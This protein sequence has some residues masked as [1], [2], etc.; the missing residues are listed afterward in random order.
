M[1][2]HFADLCILHQKHFAD[3][4]IFSQKH[5]A[6]FILNANFAIDLQK[7]MPYGIQKEIVWRN[8]ALETVA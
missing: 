8:V 6:N 2:E 1:S 4:R 7:I 5:F 3:L